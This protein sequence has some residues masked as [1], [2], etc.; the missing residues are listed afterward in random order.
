M[1]LPWRKRRPKLQEVIIDKNKN[2]SEPKGL[3]EFLERAVN[4]FDN[5][6]HVQFMETAERYYSN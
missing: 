1:L 6:P 3:R 2:I 5:L 4:E